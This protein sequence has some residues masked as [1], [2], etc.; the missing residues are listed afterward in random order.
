GA[1]A[2]AC[3]SSSGSWLA[4]GGQSGRGLV[5]AGGCRSGTSPVE[6]RGCTEGV[7]RSDPYRWTVRDIEFDAVGVADTLE[8][9]L[10][11]DAY[12]DHDLAFVDELG[13]PIQ[14]Q[15]LSEQSNARP[16]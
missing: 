13:R 5:R 14:P 1:S 8:R 7:A 15:R 9:D 10:A 16:K 4:S 2:S 11:G 12:V 6:P 3:A